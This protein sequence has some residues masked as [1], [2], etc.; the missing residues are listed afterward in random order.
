MTL[1][2]ILS[3]EI[4]FFT[5]PAVALDGDKGY[6]ENGHYGVFYYFI[7]CHICNCYAPVLPSCNF[8]VVDLVRN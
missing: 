4:R 8:K 7:I 5:S 3:K 2:L 6:K 1:T